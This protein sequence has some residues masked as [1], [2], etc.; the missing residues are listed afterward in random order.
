MRDMIDP[1]VRDVVTPVVRDGSNISN[2][3]LSLYIK[4]FPYTFPFT[5][6]DADARVTSQEST[7]D[8]NDVS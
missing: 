6:S 2:R 5:F 3:S 4:N 8:L 7:R 1:T